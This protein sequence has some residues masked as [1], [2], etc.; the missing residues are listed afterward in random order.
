MNLI[1]FGLQL[2][3][4]I[5]GIVSG[6]VVDIPDLR[7]QLRQV[8]TKSLDQC[9]INQWNIFGFIMTGNNNCHALRHETASSI[10]S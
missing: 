8:F 10:S 1:V 7:L 3:D 2:L 9:L 5:E 6:T 4:L